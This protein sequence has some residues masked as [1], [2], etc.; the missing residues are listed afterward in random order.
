[1]DNDIL[2]RFS[3]TARKLIISS[4][5]FAYEY[6]S[7]NVK[8]IH[9]FLVLLSEDVSAKDYLQFVGLDIED[10]RLQI[11][12]LLNSSKISATSTL[13]IS[14]E[15]K[16]LL[17]NAYKIAIDSGKYLV[18][19]EEI[20][21]AF[22]RMDKVEVVKELLEHKNVSEQGY[23]SFLSTH[24]QVTNGIS[25]STN[26]NNKQI[27][28][29]SQQISGMPFLSQMGQ[30]AE[31]D[32]MDDFLQDLNDS[33]LEDKNKDRIV[34]RDKEIYRLITI[35]SR[36]YK[37]NPILIGEPGVGKT[38]V[39]YGFVDMLNESIDIAY[40][41]KNSRVYSLSI[42]SL[43][44]GSKLR[45]EVEERIQSVMDQVLNDPNAILFIDEVHMIVGAGSSGG[46]DSMDVSNI[47]KPYLVNGDIK[48]IGATTRAEYQKTIETDVALARRFQPIYVDEL[49]K[50]ATKDVLLSV[51]K[52]LE[53]YH[54]IKI[55]DNI[56]DNVIDL[57][58]RYIKDRYFP[59]KAIDIL[60]ESSANVKI[61]AQ[62]DNVPEIT[63]LSKLLLKTQ[64]K[65]RKLLEKNNYKE[66]YKLKKYEDELKIQIS[67]LQS[68][69][70][71][72]HSTKKTKHIKNVSIE[73]V[74]RVVRQISKVPNAGDE[75]INQNLS[76]S[77]L[78]SF[79]GIIGQDNVLNNVTS[80]LKRSFFGI[81]EIKK[82]IASFLFLGPTGVGKTE[83]AKRIALEYFPADKGF[84]QLNMSE[85]M[86]A[87]SVAKLIGA[88]PGYVGY[89]E[90]GS[91]TTHIKNHPYSVVLFDEVEKAHPDV[92]NL[93]LQILDEG[94]LQDGKG[95]KTFFNNTVIVLT[96]NIGVE[97]VDDSMR[98]IGFTFTDD[99]VST[100][101][102]FNDKARDVL[103][104]SLKRELRPELLNRI[105]HI[106][107]FNYLSMEHAL[108]IVT[109][110]VEEYSL[111]FLKKGI[112]LEVEPLVL[113]HLT[114][115]GYKKEYGARN[116]RRIVVTEI[117]NKVIDYLIEHNI[118]PN[119]LAP[120]NYLIKKN[121]DGVIVIE[122]II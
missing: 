34:G 58:D 60:D 68:G 36:K 43:I 97:N 39:V 74:V 1:M 30:R 10:T 112:L 2:S 23:I 111:G 107:V 19:V 20:F 76:K 37:N 104:E 117:V 40:N 9:F 110:L 57:A 47:L 101:D 21:V 85:Y 86:E 51:K 16:D 27:S 22:L 15:Y 66:A 83:L 8:L 113:D 28:F 59:D 38:A 77:V 120:K 70:P 119:P 71:F 121:V 29:G 103:E 4:I 82:P 62:Y 69:K 105:D 13:N 25:S 106:E 81:R 55:D 73:D 99:L 35:L 33:R 42:A 24:R 26:F 41:L 92:L 72:G 49:S 17:L 109:N 93:L 114:N 56:L 52:G 6:K 118:S 50:S 64:S 89:D 108:L 102:A 84:L 12:N 87:H 14:K 11:I 46:R 65:K 7:S 44:A 5:N 96:S 94:V 48:I 63:R 116:L 88:P 3:R 78:T 32:F 75:M 45:G 91:L 80:I 122:Q 18:G 31:Y 115:K 53:A 100:Y 61:G 54:H 98:S 67:N 95:N 79:Q 90:G